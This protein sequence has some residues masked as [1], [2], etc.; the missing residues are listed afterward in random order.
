MSRRDRQG[1]PYDAYVPDLLDR[2]ELVLPG[3]LAA[4]VADAETAVRAL[5]D[6]GTT[7]VSLEGLARFLLRAESV[8]SSKIEGLEAAPRRLLEAGAV[9]THG[10][11]AGDRVA[12]EVLGNIAAMES[13]VRLAVDA[14]T[15]TTDDL[16]AIHHRLMET[17]PH[18]SEA[19][20]YRSPA[21]RRNRAAA[22]QQ[23]TV[24]DWSARLTAPLREVGGVL[25]TTQNWIGGS[26][27]NPCSASF[28][29]PPADHVRPLLDDL[30]RYLNGDDHSPLVQAAIAHAQFET[31]HPFADGNGRTGRALIHLILRRRGLAPGFV[32]PISLVLATWSRDYIAGLTAFRHLHPPDATERS[33]AA[34]PWLRTMAAA[35]R[36]ACLDAGTYATRIDGLAE[37]WRQR[38]G[39]V[40]AGSAAAAILGVLPGVPV[41]TVESAARLI[42][43]STVRTGEA[44]N[45]LADAGILRQRDLTRARYRVF[46]APDVLDLFLSLERSLASPMGDTAVD[47]PVRPVPH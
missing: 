11:E 26:S 7:H 19:Q 37:T 29:P 9:L 25:R 12:V 44:I 17:S 20:A 16:L 30:L 18:P 35:T 38:L 23:A 45:R 46:E 31:I 24:S 42:D 21:S 3:D 14:D 5:N 13:A 40:R 33:H 34:Q 6:A 27:Y 39:R 43:R 8:A 15:I 28:V 2:W 22:P 32:P 36:R 10:T 4:D 1:C 47:P 41:L